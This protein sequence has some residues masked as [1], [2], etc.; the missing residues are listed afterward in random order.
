VTDIGMNAFSNCSSLKDIYFNGTKREW[1]SLYDS[2]LSI[3]K[4]VTI[5][6]ND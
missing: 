1:D 4:D 5:H 2:S 3:K 6:F